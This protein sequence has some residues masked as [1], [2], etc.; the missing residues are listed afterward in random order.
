MIR[1]LKEFMDSERSSIF[2]MKG[3]AGTG[4]TFVLGR[5]AQWLRSEK[6]FVRLMAPTG[7]AARI[8]E[9]KTNMPA[10]TIH[11]AIY[12]YELEGVDSENEDY[13][14]RFRLAE[15]DDPDDAIYIIDES[16]MISDVSD[17]GEI[18]KFGSG[19]LLLDLM[20]YARPFSTNRKIVF[21]GD[22]AQ[23]EP[24]RMNFSPALDVG[25]LKENYSVEAMEQ[26]LTEVFRQRSDNSVLRTA[27]LLREE[28]QKQRPEKIVI[29]ADGKQIQQA[30]ISVDYNQ[31]KQILQKE[32]IPAAV[33]ICYRNRDVDVV[34][35]EMRVQLSHFPEVVNEG[36]ILMVAMNNYSHDVLFMNGDQ[37]RV[38]SVS[39]WVERRE[40]V[41]NYREKRGLRV[42]LSFREITVQPFHSPEERYT[43]HILENALTDNDLQKLRAALYVDLVNRHRKNPEQPFEQAKKRDAR[44]NALILK[45]GY[46]MTCHKAQGGEWDHIFVDLEHNN[47]PYSRSFIRWAYTAITRSSRTLSIQN[48]VHYEVSTAFI[49]EPPEKLV[50]LKNMVPRYE[51]VTI[52]EDDPEQIRA[53]PF[54]KAPLL[55]IEEI[56]GLE[57][58][59]LELVHFPYRIRVTFKKELDVCSIDIAFKKK[60]VKRDFE[61]VHFST[62]EFSR[63]AVSCVKAAFD[64]QSFVHNPVEPFRKDFYERL[65]RCCLVTG[66]AIVNIVEGSYLDTFIV[67]TDFQASELFCYYDK[68]ER[69]TKVQP[70]SLEPDADKKLFRLLELLRVG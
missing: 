9:N 26:S 5:F 30:P 15:N 62:D 3:Y 52:S 60:G 14:V 61:V 8:L 22:P 12:Q 37:L 10:S 16:S 38:A 23:L 2:L 21:S 33:W 51:N 39:D 40:V 53:F 36:E 55:A 24:I 34:N 68:T 18:Y 17:K 58:L 66:V 69:Y 49:V 32:H 42:V 43:V 31:Y 50:R 44:Y 54:L 63:K 46:A 48:P 56:A 59:N 1:A 11:R 13:F 29:T 20:D 70:R 64:G 67:D 7:R 47:P 4:K 25:Y 57:G 65:Q 45:Y 41:F 19:R 28:L 27:T 35:Q 6:R